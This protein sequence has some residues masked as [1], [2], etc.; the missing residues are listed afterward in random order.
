MANKTYIIKDKGKGLINDINPINLIEIGN[1]TNIIQPKSVSFLIEENRTGGTWIDGKP[2]YRKVI[3]NGDPNPANSN[4]I[5]KRT[6]TEG[7]SKIYSI[8]EYTKTTD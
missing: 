5:I 1:N 8:L 7:G 4:I 2:I 3:N 6:N